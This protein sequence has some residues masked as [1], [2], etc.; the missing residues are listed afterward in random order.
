MKNNLP[1]ISVIVP[2]YNHEKYLQQRLDSIFN[3]TYPNFEVILL[4]DC[5]TDNSRIILAEYRQNPK[6]A[7]CIFNEINTGNTFVQWNKGIALAKGEFIWIAESD[8]FCD[9]NFLQE[10]AKP[11][12]EN[13]DVVLSY[14]QSNRVNENGVIT[15]SW[16][17]QT[18]NLDSD[19]FSRDF[20]LEGNLFIEKY[21]VYK[22]VIPNASAVL[23]RREALCLL[24]DIITEKEFRYCGDWLLYFKIV[25]NQ[26][27]AFVSHSL[28]NFRYHTKSVIASVSKNESVITIIENDFLMR[29][30]MIAFLKS[31]NVAN[32]KAILQ[33]HNQKVKEVK[34]DEGMFYFHNNEKLKG[35][36]IMLTI[37]DFFVKK[38]KFRKN[39]EFKLK[40]I[41]HQNLI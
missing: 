34:Y 1:L 13:S 32:S 8:D 4:D 29:L 28:N 5:S 41:I 12:I 37:F 33:N 24:E 21:L 36:L 7:H 25:L 15:G 19:F 30:R 14:C 6:V 17:T 31:Q 40:K 39:F 23:M 11:L 9:A 38:Y 35:I 10:V 26:N 18:D 2:N 20:V 22:N 27:V 3:Q 16:K